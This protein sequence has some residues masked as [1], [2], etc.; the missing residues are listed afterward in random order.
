M[1]G[2]EAAQ[3]KMLLNVAGKQSVLAQRKDFS[4]NLRLSQVIQ[5]DQ[6]DQL[7]D[8]ADNTIKDKNGRR[9]SKLD[10]MRVLSKQILG[11]EREDEE[12]KQELDKDKN[13]FNEVGKLRNNT[14]IIELRKDSS[15]IINYT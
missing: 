6:A 11:M 9:V 14:N 1:S 3:K 8:N 5:D 4:S 13:R 10:F 15:Y 12:E 2:L 7:E